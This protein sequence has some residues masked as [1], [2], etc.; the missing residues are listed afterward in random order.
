MVVVRL[1]CCV[2]TWHGWQGTRSLMM[3]CL[4]RSELGLVSS[5][6]G[7]AELCWLIINQASMGRIPQITGRLVSS[8]NI[9]PG[10]VVRCR[11]VAGEEGI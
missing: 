7:C 8:R 5:G 2:Q 9:N 6:S 4:C 1:R 10:A 11:V 3:S